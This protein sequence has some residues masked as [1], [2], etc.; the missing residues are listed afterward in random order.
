VL[1]VAVVSGTASYKI[2][3]A[4]GHNGAGYFLLGLLLPIIGILVAG[5]MPPAE[6]REASSFE[7]TV[8]L[9]AGLRTSHGP[10]VAV[11]LRNHQPGLKRAVRYCEAG[12]HVLAFGTGTWRKWPVLFL[13]TDRRFVFIGRA[14]EH[15]L[16]GTQLDGF[17]FDESRG[18]LKSTEGVLTPDPE[19]PFT[20]SEL[21]VRIRHRDDFDP[22]VEVIARGKLARPIPR[23]P[24]ESVATPVQPVV[25]T[26][27]EL[28]R[29]DAL[30]RSGAIDDDEF[31]EMKRRAMWG[32]DGPTESSS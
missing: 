8:H 14:Y 11:F 1:V 29:L 22:Y 2:A 17:S 27:S 21:H 31:A 12:E 13:L 16:T 28:E 26:V 18:E 19:S 25:D 23:E 6:S 10:T 24:D 3:E 15:S 4:K 5:F 9:L 7:T 30:H 20:A 32:D